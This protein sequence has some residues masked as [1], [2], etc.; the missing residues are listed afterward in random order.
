M[1]NQCACLV[2]DAINLY[3]GNFL[4]S[5]YLDWC[6]Y[7]RE[8]LH[9]IYLV[10]LSKL[11]AHCEATRQYERG[12][13]Y[14]AAILRHDRAHEQTHR[15]MMRLHALAGDRT[16]ALRQYERCALALYE[17]LG[18]RPVELTTTL[19]EQI[20]LSETGGDFPPDIPPTSGTGPASGEELPGVL[21]QLKRLQLSLHEMQH[22]VHQ[23]IQ[24]VEKLL[25]DQH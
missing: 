11:I 18:V 7:E 9:Q 6:L 21:D 1:D 13:G 15:Q 2:E 24:V 25:R 22:Q 5:V 20:K 19:Y 12:L 16:A 8:R 23:N 3:R 4:E 17:E 10:L 14:A